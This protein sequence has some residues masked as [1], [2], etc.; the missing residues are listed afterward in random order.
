MTPFKRL[1]R[2]LPFVRICELAEPLRLRSVRVSL[3][4][5][6][7]PLSF[8][9]TRRKQIDLIATAR[10]SRLNHQGAW[11]DLFCP[12]QPTRNPARRPHSVSLVSSLLNDRTTA[13][14]AAQVMTLTKTDSFLAW[15][16]IIARPPPTGAQ[17]TA[18][19][20]AYQWILMIR[21]NGSVI[22]FDD[23]PMA[24]WSLVEILYVSSALDCTLSM[25]HLRRLQAE[26]HGNRFRDLGRH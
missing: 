20:P 12:T 15:L 6:V 26:P 23:P 2:R 14:H 13:R 9:G 17:H 24:S 4:T 25:P 8:S 5:T 10:L 16:R 21:T 3:T 11:P 22:E 1:N 7:P 18:N 19:K